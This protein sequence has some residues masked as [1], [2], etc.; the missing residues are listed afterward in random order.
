[1]HPHVSSWT[2]AAYEDLEAAEEPAELEEDAELLDRGGGEPERLVRV[3]E[4]L[5]SSL[6]LASVL[7]PVLVAPPAWGLREEKEGEEEEEE[8]EEEASSSNL[9]SLLAS[10]SSPAVAYAGLVLLVPFL[11]S[12]PFVWRQAEASKLHGWCR[13]DGQFHC[14]PSFPAVAC[15][16][17]CCWYCTS[18]CVSFPVVRPKMRCIMAGM[19][20]KY[21]YVGVA[22]WI[23][24]CCVQQQV[25]PVSK[26]R[27]LWVFRSCIS[28]SRS[29]TSPSWLRGGPCDRGDF[30]WCVDQVIDVPVGG[31][32]VQKLW[33]SVVAVHR[34]SSTS[35]SCRRDSSPWS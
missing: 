11:R 8:E 25:L 17:G 29:S 14:S 30:Q 6:P 15:A 4:R 10:S 12:F 19:D 1:M 27:K 5:G 22:W 21:S 23:C 31:L 24:P 2:P 34:R 13:Q 20:Q 26:C 33:L 7:A 16:G 28:A 9:F 18:R 32:M 35:S 3:A